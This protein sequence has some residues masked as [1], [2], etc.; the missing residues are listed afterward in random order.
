MFFRHLVASVLLGTLSIWVLYWLSHWLF[1]DSLQKNALMALM[2]FVFFFCHLNLTFIFNVLEVLLDLALHVNVSHFKQFDT[3][4]DVMSST[5]DT[6]SFYLIVIPT[7]RPVCLLNHC[8]PSGR[9]EGGKRSSPMISLNLEGHAQNQPHLNHTA[10]EKYHFLLHKVFTR[11]VWNNK[12]SFCVC[13]CHLPPMIAAGR[14]NTG[15]LRKKK[16]FLVLPHISTSPPE[17]FSFLFQL[18]SNR[19]KRLLLY[20]YQGN[21]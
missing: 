16:A 9:E 12:T 2:I 15:T 18:K 6:L 14:R 13:V 19:M 17:W 5:Y 4:N 1:F 21:I 3:T 10:G 7:Q 11:C 8:F 20:Y